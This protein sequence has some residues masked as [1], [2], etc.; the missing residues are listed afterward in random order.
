MMQSSPFK[1]GEF[2]HLSRANIQPNSY[3]F[4]VTSLESDRWITCRD[5]APVS[6][7]SNF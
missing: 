1:S 3:K 4:G 2:Y 6:K 5:D 7:F